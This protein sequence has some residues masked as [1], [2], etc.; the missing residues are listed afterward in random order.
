MKK[1]AF[2]ACLS[3]QVITS[4][5]QTPDII[6]SEVDKMNIALNLDSIQYNQA[7]TLFQRIKLDIDSINSLTTHSILNKRTSITT[8]CLEKTSLIRTILDSSQFILYKTNKTNQRNRVLQN[9]PNLFIPNEF[10]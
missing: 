9:Y 5:C 4:F 6:R 1:I 10:D 2:L 8:K 7:Y 3:I